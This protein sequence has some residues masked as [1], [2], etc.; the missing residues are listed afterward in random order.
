MFYV[1]QKLSDEEEINIDIAD[2]VYTKCAHCGKEIPVDLV[3]LAKEINNFD[4]YGLNLY[5]SECH[6][7]K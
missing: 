5:C 3:V 7:E 1:K 2:N 4:L 6:P